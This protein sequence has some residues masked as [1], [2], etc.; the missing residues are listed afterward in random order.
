MLNLEKLLKQSAKKIVSLNLSS[1]FLDGKAVWHLHN[2]LAVNRTLV[3]LNLSRNGLVDL[4]GIYIMRALVVV[5]LDVAQHPPLD[6]R[7]LQEQPWR[8]LRRRTGEYA[9]SQRDPVEGGH[10]RQPDHCEG[11][12]LAAEGPQGKQRHAHESRRHRSVVLTKQ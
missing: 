8:R 9:G 5:S 11:R 10:L 12:E 1:C 4:S 3:S 2:G 7:P 6:A